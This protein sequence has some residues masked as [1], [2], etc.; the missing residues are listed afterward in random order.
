MDKEGSALQVDRRGGRQTVRHT[1]I[2]YCGK[3]AFK[4]SRDRKVSLKSRVWREPGILEET[5]RG[6][7]IQ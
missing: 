4:W 2:W 3:E 1:W 7:L 6:G 5:G